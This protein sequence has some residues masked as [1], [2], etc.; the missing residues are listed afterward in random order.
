MSSTVDDST[1]AG[2]SARLCERG[3]ER[4]M[5]TDR[6]SRLIISYREEVGICHRAGYALGSSSVQKVT[7]MLYLRYSWWLRSWDRVATISLV[8]RTR[9]TAAVQL[10]RPEVHG[11]DDGV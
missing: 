10:G 4:G 11:K 1:H 2:V 6:R 7:T 8:V 3:N 5:L 9:T